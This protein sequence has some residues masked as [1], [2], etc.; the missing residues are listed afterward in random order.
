MFELAISVRRDDSSAINN[1]AVLFMSMGQL[2]DAIAALEYGIRVAPDDDTL[3]VNLARSWIRLGERGK[4]RDAMLELLK[5]KPGNA[6]ATRAL[7][8]LGNQ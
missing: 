4:A 2:N 6:L 7:Q 8:Q 3:Y 5:R 1:L